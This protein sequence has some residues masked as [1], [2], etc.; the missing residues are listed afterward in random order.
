M[1]KLYYRASLVLLPYDPAVYRLR[2]S[3]IL[4]ESISR[5]VP[6]VSRKGCAFSEQV[7]YYGAGTVYDQIDEISDIVINY[8]NRSRRATYTKLVQANYR[9]GLDSRASF[10]DWLMR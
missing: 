1:E 10:T 3:A 9:Y 2:G 7:S 6:V 4:M 8:F 5:G